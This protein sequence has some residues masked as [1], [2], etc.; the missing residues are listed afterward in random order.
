MTVIVITTTII[1]ISIIT[2]TATATKV[3]H[4]FMEDYRMFFIVSNH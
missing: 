2:T 4:D 3:T 1:V